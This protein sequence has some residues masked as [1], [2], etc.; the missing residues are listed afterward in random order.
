MHQDH[1]MHWHAVAAIFYYEPENRSTR[2][3]GTDVICRNLPTQAT[4]LHYFTRALASS[5]RPFAETE[6][7]K[8]PQ[9]LD[10]PKDGELLSDGLLSSPVTA[11]DHI[12]PKSSMPLC[13]TNQ[14]I[15]TWVESTSSA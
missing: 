7:V 6:R 13:R 4:S 9:K 10:P 3:I 12:Y 2:T 15:E 11:E 14:Q 8:H 5:V 1:N